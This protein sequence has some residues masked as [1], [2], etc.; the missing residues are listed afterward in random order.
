MWSYYFTSISKLHEMWDGIGT[1]KDG[2]YL[3]SHQTIE[4]IENLI[5][6]IDHDKNYH[7][8]A[9]IILMQIREILMV[10]MQ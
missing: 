4:I 6:S 10:T 1:M 9:E 7:D 2:D 3:E 5:K 8:Q